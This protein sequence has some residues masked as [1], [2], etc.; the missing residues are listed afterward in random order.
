[1]G[2]KVTINA[3]RFRKR[4]A[5]LGF[6]SQA[7]VARSAG[8]HPVTL[9]RY[10]TDAELKEAISIGIQRFNLLSRAESPSDGE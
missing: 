2:E 8:I 1:M 9:T 3:Q 10:L 6:R 5:E 7:E 4:L